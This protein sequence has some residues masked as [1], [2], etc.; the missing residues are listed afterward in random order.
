MC[1]QNAALSSDEAYNQYKAI[2]DSM[3]ISFPEDDIK[4]FRRTSF[5]ETQLQNYLSMHFKRMDLLTHIKGHHVFV[6]NSYLHS[7]N[8]FKDI[9]FP[10]ESIRS[11]KAF[12]RHYKLV[13]HELS[14]E[15]RKG[16]NVMRFYAHSVL[17]EN[18]ANLGQF[19]SA[20]KQHQ[21]NMD[22][23]R[24]L[25]NLYYPSAINNY[26]LLLYWHKKELDSALHYFQKAYQITESKFPKHTLIGSI[27]DNIADVYVEQ[28]LHEKAQPL[29]ALNFD[30]YNSTF[31]EGTFE[32][33]IPRLISAGA[34]L[35]TSNIHLNKL[36]EAEQVFK[37]LEKIVTH[38]ENSNLINPQSYLEFLNAKQLLLQEQHKIDAAYATAR[39]INAYAD[40]IY[41][42]A[43]ITDKRWQEE[44]NDVTIDRIALNFKIDQL[45]KEDKINSQRGKL[46]LIG[47]VSSVFILIL[48]ILFLSR[49]QHLINAKNKQLLAE[50]HLENS[51]LKVKQL[52]S[53]IKSKE[54]DLSDFAIS[55]T[56]NQDWTKHLAEQLEAIKTSNPEDREVLLESLNQDIKNKISFDSDSQ[57]FFERLDKLSDAFY[58]KLTTLY[59]NLSK[60]EIRLSSL[61]RLK[62]E[63]RSIA[64]LQNIT[65]ASLNTSRYRLRKKLDLSEDVD[66]DTF[67]QNL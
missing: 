16:F 9:G 18:Y 48:L 12:F 52:H 2:S 37:A 58:S 31:N 27:R 28:N 61:I 30:F 53:E 66:L 34:Q 33:D 47:L 1:A 14:P 24:N 57:E 67:I 42:V 21:L 46:R 55:L 36:N 13:E 44:F 39:R 10:K 25:D 40:S 54:R 32:K 19:D 15:D 41:K 43:A 22:F 56:Q 11:Y 59:P 60:N 3:A 62:I 17:A 23:T 51:A 38:Q 5:N 49:R 64:T 26:G 20:K 63:S 50:Q 29:Y 7:G 6:L 45:E 4:T 65:M 35:V 8:W